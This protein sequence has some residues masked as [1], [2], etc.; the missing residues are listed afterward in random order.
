MLDEREIERPSL[1]IILVFS[2][3]KQMKST[4][5]IKATTHIHQRKT[6]MEMKEGGK[7]KK[8]TKTKRIQ[9]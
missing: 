8:K 7:T 4:M 2:I 6:V 9:C 5:T 1:H 3:E